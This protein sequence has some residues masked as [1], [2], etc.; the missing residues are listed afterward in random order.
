MIQVG[1]RF[2]ENLGG[3]CKMKSAKVNVQNGL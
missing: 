1:D 2:R 3:E